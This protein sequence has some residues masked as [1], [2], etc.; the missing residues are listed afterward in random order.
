[1]AGE[2]GL[3]LSDKGGIGCGGLGTRVR[4]GFDFGGCAVGDGVLAALL[5]DFEANL[6]LAADDGGGTG[7]SDRAMEDKG[8]CEGFICSGSGVWEG[9]NCCIAVARAS[10]NCFSVQTIQLARG[11]KCGGREVTHCL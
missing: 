2:L 1:M 9:S 6:P 4:D 11:V 8:P 10:S 3:Y 7:T 5:V